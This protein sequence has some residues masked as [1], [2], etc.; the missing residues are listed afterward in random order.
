MTT[1]CASAFPRRIRARVLPVS[2]TLQKQRGRRECRALAATHG[3]P[4]TKNAGGSHHRSNRTSGIPCAMGLRIIR[5]LPGDR[6]DCPRFATTR[7]AHC[8]GRQ[9]RGVRTTRLHRPRP[10]VVAQQRLMNRGHRIPTSRIV[11]I[12]RTPLRL[13][14]DGAD[15]TTDLGAESRIIL[16]IGIGSC[17]AFVRR[18]HGR[19]L[20]ELWQDIWR[21]GSASWTRFSAAVLM[22]RC[23]R[24]HRPR[25]VRCR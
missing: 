9:H 11:T 17:N 15:E 13:R 5:A 21:S 23:V 14:R 20:T 24:P 22:R 3:P 2:W 25:P 18:E 7:F 19:G 10:S 1:E 16:E 8:A 12:A 6:L 4:A